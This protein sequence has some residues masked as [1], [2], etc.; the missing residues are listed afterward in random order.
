MT[1]DAE[2]TKAHA[3]QH[4]IDHLKGVLIIDHVGW[5]GRLALRPKLKELTK[6]WRETQDGD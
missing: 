6:Y 2:D 3:L 4:E 5:R 1:I